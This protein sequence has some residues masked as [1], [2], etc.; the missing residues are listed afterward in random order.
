MAFLKSVL[1]RLFTT[2]VSTVV[3]FFL[4]L[5]LIGVLIGSLSKKDIL[6]E[7][8]VLE[9]DLSNQL[10]D[11]PRSGSLEVLIRDSSGAVVRRLT[12]FVE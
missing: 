1:W 3:S 7:K 4:V 9:I 11:A 10:T 5:V 8:A 12:R 2:V 6:P